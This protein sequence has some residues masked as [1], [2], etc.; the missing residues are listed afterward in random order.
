MLLDDV[1]AATLQRE[2]LRYTEPPENDQPT[3]VGGITLAALAA[4]QGS[5]ATIAQLKAL[6]ID[7]ASA[8]IRKRFEDDLGRLHFAQIGYE[9]LRVQMLDFAY[10]SGEAR[11]VR[12]LQRTVG[13]AGLFVTGQMDDRTWRAMAGISSVLLNNAL[14]ATRA[15]AAI[16]GGVAD[17][18]LQAGVMRRAIEFV[19]VP[20]GAL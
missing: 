12:W 10:N 14:A 9:P 20:G 18:H 1:V 16:G 8:I 11:A 5:P 6:T 7:D 2:G 15:H 3:G 19:V 13:L 17:V 4:Y